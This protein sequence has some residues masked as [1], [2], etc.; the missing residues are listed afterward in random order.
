MCPSFIEHVRKRSWEKRVVLVLPR[1]ERA[2][3]KLVVQRMVALT[4][5]P[6]SGSTFA[7][8][9][10]VFDVRIVEPPRH[11]VMYSHRVSVDQ[12]DQL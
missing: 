9:E 2:G 4:V 7:A 6:C 12:H 5:S 1:D 3:R 8:S 10:H 11:R